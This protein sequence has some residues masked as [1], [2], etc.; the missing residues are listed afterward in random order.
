MV[1]KQRE[2]ITFRS[3]QSVITYCTLVALGKNMLLKTQWIF[4]TSKAQN[5]LLSTTCVVQSRLMF[6]SIFY[7]P[8]TLFVFYHVL[9]LL[10][11]WI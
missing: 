5:M 3:R 8:R 7:R 11:L 10:Q 4:I 9:L 1:S 6:C 2:E